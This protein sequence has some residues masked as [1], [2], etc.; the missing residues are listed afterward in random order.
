MWAVYEEKS[1]LKSLKKAPR[2]VVVRYEAWKRVVELRG[3][4]GL[5]LIK[6]FHDKSMRG[7]WQGHRSSRLGKQ[8][9][10]IYT[11]QE[12]RLQVSAV[13]LTPHKY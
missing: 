1:V 13:E 4:K 3:L 6:G 12:E 8:W 10:I 11:V 9:R 2:E 5:F 7:K